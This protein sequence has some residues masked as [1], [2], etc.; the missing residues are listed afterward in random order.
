MGVIVPCSPAKILASNITTLR[1]QRRILP[2]GFQTDYKT[3]LLPITEGIDAKLKSLGPFPKDGEA[4]P[5][6][7]VPLAE[8]L[9]LIDRLGPT[10]VD[11]A[12]GY[13]DRW[14]APEYKAILRHLSESCQD[15]QKR[16]NVLLLVRTGRNLTRT[17]KSTSHADFADAP[18]TTRTEGVIAKQ[19]AQDL[20]VLILIRQNGAS[21]QDWRDCPFWWPVIYTPAN[22]RTTLFAHSR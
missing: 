13:E 1:P 20:P 17:V 22:S 16:G 14:D 4:P 19:A 18:D 21:A 10:F 8:A 3:R 6:F 5:P 9:D 15:T 2:V 11:F 12:P 7:E